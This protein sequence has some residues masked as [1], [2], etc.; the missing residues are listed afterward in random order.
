MDL[1]VLLLIGFMSILKNRCSVY[2]NKCL[3]S[4]D[5]M[6][7]AMYCWLIK[8]RLGG[9]IYLIEV[10]IIIRTQYTVSI[11]LNMFIITI[12]ILMNTKRV[13]RGGEKKEHNMGSFYL[14]ENSVLEKSGSEYAF[15]LN[16]IYI[17]NSI[18]N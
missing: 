12:Y 10:L 5:G 13:E 18:E 11:H 15:Y 3:G 2:P 6:M 7:G 4:L 17:F 16:N 1:R 9:I 14:Q 8:Q